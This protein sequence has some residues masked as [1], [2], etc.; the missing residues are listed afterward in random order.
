M[1]APVPRW[2]SLHKALIQPSG[3]QP[4]GIVVLM[5]DQ[6]DTQLLEE[7][8]MHSERLASIGRLAAGVAHEIGNPITGIDSLA[9]LIRYESQD[10]ELAEMASQI[11][12]QTQRVSRIVQSLMNFAHAGNQSSEH[13]SVQISQ[14][15]DEAVQLLRLS[16]RSMDIAFDNQC[17]P[18]LL[19]AGR[20]PTPGA[21]V[22][23][24][25]SAMPSDASQ[26]GDHIHVTS[27]ADEHQVILRVIDQGHGIAPDTLD[28]IFEPFFTTKGRGQRH[29]PGAG[30]GVSSIVEEHYGNISIHSPVADGQGTCVKVSLP[31]ATPIRTRVGIQRMSHI[32]VVEDETIIRQALRRLLAAPRLRSYRC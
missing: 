32:L 12:E 3:G 20:R 4:G 24:T 19:G 15:I 26:P 14:C 5:E 16:K 17:D 2:Y 25:C 10:P 28:R 21:G 6:T 27:E 11:Q 7:E 9:Q 1:L 30:L 22:S 8:L 23:S 31:R 13:E 18:E 29:R